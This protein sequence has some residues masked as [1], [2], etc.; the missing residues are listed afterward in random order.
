MGKLS[1]LKEGLEKAAK[2]LDMSQA[3]R[4]QRAAEQGFDTKMYHSSKT[5]FAGSPQAEEAAKYG[6]PVESQFKIPYGG[7]YFANDAEITDTIFAQGT[8]FSGTAE[9]LVR[10][11]NNFNAEY[12]MMSESD[13]AVLNKIVNDVIDE[14]DIAEA[15]AKLDIPIEDIDAF[16]AFTDGEFFQFFGR[17]KQNQVLEELKKK[18]YDSVTFP[19]KQKLYDEV[20]TSTVLFNPSNIR[21]TSAAFDPAQKESSNLLAQYAPLAI[22]AARQAWLCR[23]KSHKQQLHK[24]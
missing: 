8:P 12:R 5:V 20:T 10:K 17:D 21:S 3:A 23:H 2:A 1:A 4:M 15:S 11:G 13:R 7:A 16:D 18:G 19:D 9:Y 14:E 6:V 24:S 22:G